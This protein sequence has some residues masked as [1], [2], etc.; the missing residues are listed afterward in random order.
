MKTIVWYILILCAF[1][2][3][4]ICHERDIQD[5]CKRNGSSYYSGW[6]VTIYCSEMK[7]NK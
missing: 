2:I 4:A 7:E 1:I 5:E 3:G 6:T